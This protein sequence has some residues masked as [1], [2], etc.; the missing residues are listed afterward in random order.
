M[1]TFRDDNISAGKPGV[2]RPGFDRML[3]ELRSRPKGR[4]VG[5]WANEQS[6]LTRL[7]E[8]SWDDLRVIF[9]MAGLNEVHTGIQ[10]I[11]GIR[12]GNSM[13][14]RIY[15]VVDSEFSERTKVKVQEAHADLFAEGRPSGRPPFGYRS[16]KDEHGRPAWVRHPDQAE[17]VERIF[18]MA[19]AGHAIAAI[20]D[21]LNDEKVPTRSAGWK[22]KDGRTVKEWRAVTVRG[23][24]TS[25]SV[26][27]LRAH[28][29]RDENGRPIRVHTVPARWPA[30]IDVD[31]WRQ[32]QRILGQPSEV[33]GTNGDTYRVR[34]KPAAKPRRY[35]LSGGRRRS[36]VIGEAGTGEVYGVLRCGKCGFP[37][38]AQTQG[39]R[40][41][42]RVPAYQCHPKVDK[43]ACG[44]VSISPASEVE[45][46]VVGA[47]QAELAAAPSFGIG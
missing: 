42:S 28:T 4:V 46:L 30:I 23:L 6:R 20:V 27:G 12:P 39:R 40:D 16:I 19:L 7:G 11:I 17:V 35:L 2:K 24:L 8:T 15:A 14:G 41:G 36:G 9:N 13:A 29:E 25:P 5:V 22:F 32:V 47:I 21:W 33:L 45:D 44:G 31:Q 1:L 43:A 10:G 3:H 26:A 18:E 37:L 34:T 38:L